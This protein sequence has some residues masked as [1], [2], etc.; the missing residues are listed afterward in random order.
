MV[1]VFWVV[2]S[3]IMGGAFALFVCINLLAVLIVGPLEWIDSYVDAV[4]ELREELK[5]RKE[6]G[7][8]KPHD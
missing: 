3:A 4:S 2:F 5:R 1:D 8:P 7:G 6:K